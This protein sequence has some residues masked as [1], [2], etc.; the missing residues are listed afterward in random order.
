MAAVVFI[1]RTVKNNYMY[2]AQLLT[3]IVLKTIKLSAYK[4][5]PGNRIINAIKNF[6]DVK[7]GANVKQA[8]GHNGKLYLAISLC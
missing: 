5:I 3:G 4:K 6:L 7:N 8:I 2:G 1:V